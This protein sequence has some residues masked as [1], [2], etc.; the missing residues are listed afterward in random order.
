MWGDCCPPMLQ[1]ESYWG[2]ISDSQV[3]L[4]TRESG[5]DD[6]QQTLLCGW[7]GSFMALQ[8]YWGLFK[9]EKVLVYLILVVPSPVSTRNYVQITFSIQWQLSVA[10]VER[11]KVTVLSSGQLMSRR[12]EFAS[13]HR[14]AISFNVFINSNHEFF[15]ANF[16]CNNYSLALTLIMT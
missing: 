4:F 16:T 13:C 10:Y 2:A 6:T 1:Q 11:R 3:L 12:P 9:R 5:R 7:W 14:P 15:S 8:Y